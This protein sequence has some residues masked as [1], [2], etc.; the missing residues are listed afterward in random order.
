MRL[1]GIACLALA[2]LAGYLASQ[3]MAIDL[4]TLNAD[5]RLGAQMAFNALACCTLG[6]PVIGFAALSDDASRRRRL[7]GRPTRQQRR[8]KARAAFRA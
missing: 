8:R 4:T 7:A 6:L 3:M 5:G 1:F 2:A